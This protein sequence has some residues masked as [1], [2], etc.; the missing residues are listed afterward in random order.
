M[1]P[2]SISSTVS[3]L[4]VRVTTVPAEPLC[5]G[6]SAPMPAQGLCQDPVHPPTHL[7][8]SNR[9]L[10]DSWEKTDGFR[11]FPSEPRLNK[12][13]FVGVGEHGRGR[14]LYPRPPTPNPKPLNPRPAVGY[15]RTSLIGNCLPPRT[16]PGPTSGSWKAVSY[17]RSNPVMVPCGAVQAGTVCR[18]A[19]LNS[20]GD[21]RAVDPTDGSLKSTVQCQY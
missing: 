5:T 19:V 7:A 9:L 10:W 6:P 8:G 2:F 20:R 16:A 11:L 1:R 3:D 13:R 18:S 14:C 21:V 12:R 15:R 17:E 4:C